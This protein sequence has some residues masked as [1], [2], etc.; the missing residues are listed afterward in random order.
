M[1]FPESTSKSMSAHAGL[2]AWEEDLL[3][4]YPEEQNECTV[5]DDGTFRDYESNTR[6]EVRE[7]YRLNH[8]YQTLEFARQK[9]DCAECCDRCSRGCALFLGKVAA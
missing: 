4:R 9:K 8:R 5:S 1:D 7:F 6:P 3:K 2:E